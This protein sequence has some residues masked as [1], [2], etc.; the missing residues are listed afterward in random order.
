MGCSEV[1]ADAY[2]RPR[3]KALANR[4]DAGLTKASKTR[5]LPGIR[6]AAARRA[7][8]EQLVESWR[9]V[10]FP[11]VIETRSISP[12]RAL[13]HDD[14]FDPLRAAILQRRAG[15]VE[16]AFWLVFLFVHFG[17][18]AKSKWHY[19]RQLYGRLGGT[20][21]WDWAAVSSNPAAFRAWFDPNLQ[22]FQT[23]QTG[24]FGNHRKYEPLERTGRVIESYVGWIN[25]PRTHKELFDD[26]VNAANGDAREAFD[27][28]YRSMDVLSF[29]R[30][31]KFDYLTTVGRIGLS[32]IEPGSTYMS[33]ATGPKAGARMLFGTKDVAALL[34]SYLLEVD[35]ELGLGMH[36][37]E[38]ALCNW[39]KSPA[40]FR[41]YRS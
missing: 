7:F 14:M 20:Q 26:A 31:G 9:R 29:G 21:T 19:A 22:A 17:P 6:I 36:V 13:P 40:E 3:D 37:L 23:G 12:K 39:Q 34:D 10:S 1:C 11:T 28:L 32:P 30:T 4:I 25:P 33:G 27:L 35:G 8:I 15:D 38:D 16:E 41:P 24:G 2:L 5:K 18:H